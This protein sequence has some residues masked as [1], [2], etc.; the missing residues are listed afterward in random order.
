MNTLFVPSDNDI[1][2][3]WQ[4][5][6]NLLSDRFGALYQVFD[7]IVDYCN[8]FTNNHTDYIEFPSITLSFG[9][10][11][12]VFGGWKVPIVVD[13]FGF[14]FESIKL[15]I[16]VLCTLSFINAIHNRFDRLFRR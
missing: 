13:G 2:S 3:M 14:L 12:F 16:S 7:I 1:S 9:N 8:S 6:D 4:D 11:P 5:W 10:T 15:I